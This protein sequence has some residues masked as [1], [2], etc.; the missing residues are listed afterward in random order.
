MLDVFLL[1]IMVALIRF[2][3]FATIIPGPGIVVFASVVVLTLLASASYDP[4]LIWKEE[5]LEPAR[6]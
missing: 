2:G 3:K 4:R 1:A 6:S 5:P